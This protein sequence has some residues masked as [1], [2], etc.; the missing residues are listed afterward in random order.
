MRSADSIRQFNRF[1]TKQIGVLKEGLLDSPFSLTEMRMLYELYSRSPL[2]AK[3]L[4]DDLGLDQGYVSRILKDF[5]RSG[6]L[7]KSRSEKDGR[8][9]ELALTDRARADFAE[10]DARS[11]E[12]VEAMLQHLDAGERHELERAMAEVRSLLR[13]SHRP[14]EVVLRGHRPGDMGWITY[15]HGA[16]YDRE[17]GYG[18]AF[19]AIVA[20]I[21]SDFLTNLNPERERCWIADREGEIL[22]SVFLVKD[23]ELESRAKL[24]L[25]F[26]EPHARGLG[27]GRRLVG[28]CVDFA[29]VA[30]Y[31]NVILWTQ[32]ELTAARNIYESFG[33]RKTS[34]EAHTMFGAPSVAETWLLD[35]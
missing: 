21:T 2:T 9:Y 26:V 22:G 8:E 10:L 15:R 5:Q 25:L 1:Y 30:G 13:D 28:E 11:S 27:L 29:R 35:L 6:M 34:E 7:R 4:Q 17:Y 12:Q 18:P 31:G 16:L 33:F 32:S 3:Q 20:R 24:R 14:G 19:E 23:P